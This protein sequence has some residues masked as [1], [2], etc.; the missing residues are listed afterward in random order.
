MCSV[1]FELNLTP[2]KI[3][4]FQPHGQPQGISPL[5]PKCHC[6]QNA[7]FL[8]LNKNSGIIYKLH[9]KIY[10]FI[11]FKL[12]NLII[13]KT[14]DRNFDT[15]QQIRVI[16]LHAWNKEFT[17]CRRKVWKIDIGTVVKVSDMASFLNHYMSLS[18][19]E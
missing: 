13:T 6:L 3:L 17:V 11:F 16:N 19:G 18:F 4:F 8:Y 15:K 12:I 14:G 5:S 2:G 1:K 10:W 7:P 9:S